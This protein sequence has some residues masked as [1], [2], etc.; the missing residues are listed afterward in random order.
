MSKP[1]RQF[2]K[3]YNSVLSYLFFGF[4]TT[5]VNVAVYAFC[6]KTVNLPVAVSTV[7]AWVVAVSFA[8]VTNKA[9]VF[10]S[11]SWSKT[12]AVREAISFFLCR[13]ATGVFDLFF[14]IVTVDLLDWSGSAM[15]LLSN[16]V[17]IV[18]N[19]IASKFVIFKRR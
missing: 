6:E 12:V 13:V 15:K 4:C 8:F 5:A 14:M 1:I 17:V 19:Y 2:L 7:I 18:L 10:R 9:F 16:M 11:K 3:R